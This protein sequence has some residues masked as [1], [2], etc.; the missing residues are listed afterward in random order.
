MKGTVIS[1][2]IAVGLIAGAVLLSKNAVPEV[3]TA[4]TVSIVDGKQIIEIHAKGGYQPR[5]ISAQS[6]IPTILRFDTSGT[7]DCSA[8]V[9]I[10]SMDITQNLP[11]SGSV[12]IPIGTQGTSTL[13]GT[14]SMGMY[15]FEIDFK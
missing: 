2:L 9:R 14:C 7:F 4:A 15:P 10:P 3:A 6:N 13:E 8:S 12:D 5:R 1:T 11:P